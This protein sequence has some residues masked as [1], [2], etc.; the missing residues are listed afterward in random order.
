MNIYKVIDRDSPRCV[1]VLGLI[2]STVCVCVIN[3]QK[4]PLPPM[5]QTNRSFRGEK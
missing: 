1:K 2:T 4:K 3:T 5:G